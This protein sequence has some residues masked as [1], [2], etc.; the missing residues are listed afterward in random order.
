M[1]SEQ[2]ARLLYRCAYGLLG[3]SLLFCGVMMGRYLERDRIRGE[4]RSY[5]ERNALMIHHKI[6]FQ[7]TNGQPIRCDE[8][9]QK[10]GDIT[11][12]FL[13]PHNVYQWLRK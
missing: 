10:L 11:N 2:N 4:L 3:I 6:N 9:S 5:L 13:S 8:L 12:V 7:D 1:G